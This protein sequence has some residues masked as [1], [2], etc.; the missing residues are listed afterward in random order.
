M[1]TRPPLSS[2][3]RELPQ[4]AWEGQHRM[5]RSRVLLVED[6]EINQLVAQG[7]LEHLG[8]QVDLAANG[9]EAVQAVQA[10]RYDVVLMDCLMPVMDGYEST[11]RIRALPG[12]ERHV[13]IVAL[14]ASAMPDDRDRC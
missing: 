9:A 5:T 3:S 10:T 2:C 13:P 8:C 7:M 12:E 4:P 6:S 11:A 14:T 1:R